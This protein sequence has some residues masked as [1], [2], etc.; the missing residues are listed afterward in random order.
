MTPIEVACR[1]IKD[2]TVLSCGAAIAYPCRQLEGEVLVIGQDGQSFHA[3]RRMDAVMMTDGTPV[4]DQVWD[5]AE[6]GGWGLF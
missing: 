2:G 5:A 6:K 3:E 4:S 1:H